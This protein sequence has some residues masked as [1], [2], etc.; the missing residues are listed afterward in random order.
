[1][2]NAFSGRAVPLLVQGSWVWLKVLV[3]SVI[4]GSAY[5]I[6]GCPGFHRVQFELT[7]QAAFSAFMANI[8]NMVVLP[9]LAPHFFAEDRWKI[10]RELLYNSCVVIIAIIITG[11]T[12]TLFGHPF[13]T[14]A[15][16]Y[17]SLTPVSWA[18]TAGITV[19]YQIVRYRKNDRYAQRIRSGI[20]KRNRLTG[21]KDREFSFTVLVKGTEYTTSAYDIIYLRDNLPETTIAFRGSNGDALVG[22]SLLEFRTVR[23]SVRK[24]SN[25]Y[26]CHR[27]WTVNMD[28]VTGIHADALGFLLETEH[29]EVFIPVSSSLNE[30]LEGRLMK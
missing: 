6:W 5:S 15:H 17:T 13:S 4:T 20:R 28:M 25:F 16:W 7:A 29:K 22:S 3:L 21:D 8:L 10:A 26:R 23:E 30:D 1:M 14:T 19:L 18:L 27:E 9:R 12:P 2:G 24:L 11:F